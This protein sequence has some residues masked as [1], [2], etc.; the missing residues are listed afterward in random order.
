MF[1]IIEKYIGKLTKEDIAKFASSKGANLSSDELDFTYSFIKRNWQD[2]IKNPNLFDIDR[3]ES[4]FSPSNF[5]KIKQ[6]YNEYR[7]YL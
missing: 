5:Q 2:V 7:T 3:Y 6:I 4:H 1:N